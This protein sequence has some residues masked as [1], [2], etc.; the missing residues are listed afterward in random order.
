[1]AVYIYRRS[2]MVFMEF[3]DYISFIC[4]RYSEIGNYIFRKGIWLMKGDKGLMK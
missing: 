2:R 4:T 3:D 1:M